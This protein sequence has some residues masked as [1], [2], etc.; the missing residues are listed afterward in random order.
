MPS[1]KKRLEAMSELFESE[2]SYVHDLEVWCIRFRQFLLNTS[3]LTSQR[4]FALNKLIFINT[5]G[6][7]NLHR[8]IA[9][10]IGQKNE[11]CRRNVLNVYSEDI[12]QK[13]DL[14]GVET[15][16]NKAYENLMYIDIYEKYQE[17]FTLY[18]YYTERIPKIE[19]I[20]DKEAAINQDFKLQSDAFFLSQGYKMIGFKHFL[21]RPTQK[22]ARYPLLMAAI[23]KNTTDDNVKERILRVSKNIAGKANEYDKLMGNV[24]NAFSVYKL[25]MTLK[26]KPYVESKIA[27]GLFLKDRRLLQ[28]SNEVYITSKYRNEP[29]P[30]RIYLLDQVML[31]VDVVVKKFGED[32]YIADDPMPLIKYVPIKEIGGLNVNEYFKEKPMLKMK[33]IDGSNE[34][35]LFFKTVSQC[36]ELFDAITKTRQILLDKCNPEIELI[37]YSKIGQTKCKEVCSIDKFFSGNSYSNH[38]EIRIHNLFVDLEDQLVKESQSNNNSNYSNSNLS[39]INEKPEVQ[40]EGIEKKLCDRIKLGHSILTF[41]RLYN[42]PSQVEDEFVLYTYPGGVNLKVGTEERRVLTRDIKHLQY[43]HHHKIVCFIMEQECCWSD[44]N[45]KKTVIDTNVICSGAEQCWYG[46][47]LKTSYIIVRL[48]SKTQSNYLQLYEI[49]NENGEIIMRASSQFYIGARVTQISFFE[50][51]LIA[52]S[53]DFEVVDMYTLNTHSLVNQTDLTLEYFLRY[54]EQSSAMDVIKIRQGLYLVLSKTMGFF[55]NHLGSFANVPSFFGWYVTPTDFRVYSDFLFVISDRTCVV[56]DL[57]SGT[58]LAYI[59]K[60]N[61]HFIKNISTPWLHDEDF[62]YELKIPKRDLK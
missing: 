4:K 35:I 52:C 62:L 41:D 61:L 60:P 20:V 48:S 15:G 29:R 44:F 46:K 23:A 2:K 47:T 45:N 13:L 6:I 25:L 26:Y 57:W 30:Y 28:M 33:E 31:I 39:I 19:F 17:Q 8:K 3:S 16:A 40:N 11:E 34:I 55:V 58:I 56:Y 59:V 1:E 7:M 32:I 12:Y 10:E 24:K 27:L 37:Q 43:I 5:D 51:K 54:D 21:L 9:F 38:E 50:T 14:K 42:N 49:A 18:G 53:T 36:S 22:L